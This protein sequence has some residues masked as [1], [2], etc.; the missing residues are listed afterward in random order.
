M[1]HNNLYS[2]RMMYLLRFE[3]RLTTEWYP[4]YWPR[5]SGV[6]AAVVWDSQLHALI[7]GGRGLLVFHELFVYGT[8]SFQHW[9]VIDTW[10]KGSTATGVPWII[11]AWDSFIPTLNCHHQ[12][13]WLALAIAVLIA[14]TGRGVGYCGLVN[15]SI[16]VNHNWK[17]TAKSKTSMNQM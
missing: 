4:A 1:Y 17:A 5:R 10:W 14:V 13:G 12:W 11:C 7:R 8:H 2:P 9:T 3:V 6:P 16:I 15:S